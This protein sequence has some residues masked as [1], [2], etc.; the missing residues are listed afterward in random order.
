MWPYLGIEDPHKKDIEE[1]E[2][3]KEEEY[4]WVCQ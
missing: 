3:Q 4:Q 2:L 1:H